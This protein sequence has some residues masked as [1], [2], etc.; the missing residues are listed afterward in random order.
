MTGAGELRYNGQ[1]EVREVPGSGRGMTSTKKVYHFEPT[2]A[3]YAINKI[4]FFFGHSRSIYRM[5]QK[6]LDTARYR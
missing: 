3:V 1:A 6:L 5:R 4:F 2:C